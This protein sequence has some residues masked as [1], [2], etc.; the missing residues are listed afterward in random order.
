MLIPLWLAAADKKGPE[1]LD[2]NAATVEQLEK[3]PG[4]N[5]QRAATIVRVRDHNG[6][7]RRLEELR[8]LPGITKTQYERLREFL[9]I[10]EP[11]SSE[12]R[13]SN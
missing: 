9:R 3:L 1:L 11:G 13:A 2:V 6:P 8:Q 4:M 5:R 12:K 10:G 7:Y